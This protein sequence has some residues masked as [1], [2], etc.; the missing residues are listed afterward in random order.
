MTHNKSISM[1]E[2]LS[3]HFESKETAT[4]K[5]QEQVLG[6]AHDDVWKGLGL[7]EYLTP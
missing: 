6:P 5:K 7:D 2:L 1:I 3:N 4:N